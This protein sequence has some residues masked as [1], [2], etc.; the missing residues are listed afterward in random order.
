MFVFIDESGNFDF[1]DKGTDHFVMTA[2]I[3]DDPIA[4][5]CV[6]Q[7]LKYEFMA[8]G[9][10]ENGHFH[11]TE[12][13][14]AVRDRVLQAIEGIRSISAHTIYIDKHHAAPSMQNIESM[15]GLFG[16]AI[17]K[18]LLM[19]L[20]HNS[21]RQIIMIFDGA[22]TRRQQNAF[23]AVVKPALNKIGRP[24]RIYFQSVKFDFNGQIADYIAWA[25]YVKLE[26]S[27]RRPYDAIPR[28]RG[29]D[30]NLFRYGHTRYY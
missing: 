27:E 25:H 20:P 3:A 30:F 6:L 1:S 9:G 4:S 8:E 21:K 12:D 15:Y 2:V 10:L 24:Y 26:R 28:A 11:A 22:I 13:R 7:E 19:A 16:R 17:A 23:L 29:D 18:Y 14:Q 5:A